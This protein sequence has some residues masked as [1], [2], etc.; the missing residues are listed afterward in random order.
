MSAQKWAF[1]HALEGESCWSRLLKYEQVAGILHW[2][3]AQ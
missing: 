1:A 3:N 2:K